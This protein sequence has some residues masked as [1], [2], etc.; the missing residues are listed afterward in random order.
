MQGTQGGKHL[1]RGSWRKIER[2]G[3]L[4]RVETGEAAV[5]SPTSS[6][7]AVKAGTKEEEIGK[8]NKERDP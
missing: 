3:K 6:V 4:P 8:D 7:K 2:E 5:S 1:K